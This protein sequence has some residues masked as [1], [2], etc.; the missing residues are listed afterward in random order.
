MERLE[1]RNPNGSEFLVK[2]LGEFPAQA[3]DTVVARS[4]LDLA[5]EQLVEPGL[6]L[7]I[8]V[9]PARF[10]GDLTAV[11][12]REGHRIRVVSARQGF[13]LM[14]TTGH[15]VDVA[16]NLAERTGRKPVIVVDEIGVGAGVVDRLRE[17]GEFRVV[18]FNSA[19]R[20]SRSR[21]YPNKRSE[22]WFTAAEALP[23]L[24][25]DPLDDDLAADLLAP[26]YSFGSDGSRVVEQKSSTRKRLRRSPDRADALLLT[27]VMQPPL[28]PGKA[29]KP[30]GLFVARGGIDDFGGGSTLS[31]ARFAAGASSIPLTGDVPLADWLAQLGVPVADPVANRYDAGLLGRLVGHGGVPHPFLVQGGEM[32]P[33]A[34]LTKAPSPVERMAAGGFVWN[35]PEESR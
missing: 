27:L 13:D 7:V 26:S 30:R 1:K 5:R 4:D 32:P 34:K 31:P 33:G 12:V 24:D 8:G 22:L 23:L 6:P 18:G 25:L 2:C 9:D 29:R 16:R 11:A 10:G 21:D 14:Q 17:L 35:G 15:V 3:D 19:G 28:A 20:A